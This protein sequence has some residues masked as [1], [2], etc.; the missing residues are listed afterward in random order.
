MRLEHPDRAGLGVRLAYG[1]NLYPSLDARGVLGGLRAVA[2]PLRARCAPEV[3]DFGVGAWL[4]A[5]AAA[6]FLGSESLFDELRG[7]V[8]EGGLDPFTF[9]AFPYGDFHGA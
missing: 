9:N 7:V 8:E 4:P 2:L 6:E 5:R 3:S 1:L